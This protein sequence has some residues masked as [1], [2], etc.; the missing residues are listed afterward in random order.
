MNLSLNVLKF[1]GTSVKDA[2]AF[3]KL[4]SIIMGK[5]GKKIVVV[6]AMATITNTLVAIIDALETKQYVNA[7]ENIAYISNKHK[8]V[9]EDLD[10]EIQSSKYIDEVCGN[11]KKYIEATEILGDISPKTKDAILSIGEL[12]SSY[13]VNEYFN[14][15][16]LYSKRIEPNLLIKTNSN[17]TE[18][19]VD[20]R[21]TETECETILLPL[22]DETD[23]IITGGFVGSDLK[24]I[25]TTL[26]RGGSD[27]SAAIIASSI[28]A[29][30]LEIWTDVD[31]IMTSDPRIVENACLVKRLTYREAAELAYFG[32]KVLHPK[33]IAPAVKK[34]IPV[35]VKNT[36]FPESGGTLILSKGSGSDFIK[37]IAF[38]KG[39]T[40][41]NIDSK[42]MLGAVGFLSKVFDI[43]RQHSTSV[44]LITTSE[45]SISLTIDDKTKLEG[46][47]HDLSGFADVDVA[48][49]KAIISVV[50]EGLRRTAG[51]AAKFFGSLEDINVQM[52]S[53]GASEVNLSIVVSEE[54]LIEAVKKLHNRFFS[55]IR[56]PEIFE[57]RRN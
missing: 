12:L 47:I 26:G 17:F 44:D 21:H 9:A 2:I 45:V 15:I 32:A 24:G 54:H 4:L 57:K 22:L 10:I 48:E 38:R 35:Y 42:R 18:A 25:V 7:Y 53:L 3:R 16:D 6:S 41:I 5:S 13:L 19:E 40:I 37:A 20:F 55:E 28:N 11:L 29:D 52:I 1:G 34:N 31:G 51:I 50:G 27:Y 43:F 46:I 39:I 30:S 8:S 36:F 14:S 56:H 49:N 33:T 23:L